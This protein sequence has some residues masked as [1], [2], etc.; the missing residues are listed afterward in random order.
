MTATVRY[1]ETGFLVPC[2]DNWHTLH[3]QVHD[4]M[5]DGANS[6]EGRTFLYSVL[7]SPR[8]GGQGLVT[9]RVFGDVSPSVPLDST[10]RTFTSGESLTL[11][12][13]LSLQKS[14]GRTRDNKPIPQKSLLSQPWDIDDWV[15]RKLFAAGFK[16]D[17]VTWDSPK[18]RQVKKGSTVFFIPSARFHVQ[19]HIIDAAVFAEAWLH[20]IGRNKG[21]G[22]GMIEIVGA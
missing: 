20:G 2:P 16:T 15:R 10:S 14:N 8:L 11:C 9:V 21:Y 18:K 4:V 5:F 17:S 19:G 6:H 12:L 3:Q 7:D 1:A 13:D 22:H